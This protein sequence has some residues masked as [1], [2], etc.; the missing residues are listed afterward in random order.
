MR[1]IVVELAAT[2]PG[3]V[4][5]LL[6]GR[7]RQLAAGGADAG[8]GAVERGEGSLAGSPPADYDPSEGEP[9]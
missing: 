1:A 7:A 5:L 9:V 4:P 3:G 6:E 8:A 2:E